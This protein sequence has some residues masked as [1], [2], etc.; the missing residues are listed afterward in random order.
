MPFTSWSGFIAHIVSL[1]AGDWIMLIYK[2][3]DSY[4]RH[5][6][7][8]KRRAVI[9]ISCKRG[10]T[11]VSDTWGERASGGCQ[12][13]GCLWAEG[14]GG[15]SEL[16]SCVWCPAAPTVIKLSPGKVQCAWVCFH[17]TSLFPN[18]EFIQH[19]FWRAGKGAGV[20]LPLWNGQ[21]CGLSGWGFPPQCWLHS[22][23]HVSHLK[24]CLCLSHNLQC[25]LET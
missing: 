7:G 25:Y 24:S 3:G 19:Y 8:E 22:A 10:V 21:Q 16:A 23:D 11:A 18:A 4:G 2:G 13:N 6:S 15:D 12:T 5:C 14:F 17:M 9:M 20:F 1:L